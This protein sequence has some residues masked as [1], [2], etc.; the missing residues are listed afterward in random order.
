M[1]DNVLS[2]ITNPW[3]LLLLVALAGG[4]G[5]LVATGRWQHVVITVKTLM[6]PVRMLLES[7]G[8]ISKQVQPSTASPSNSNTE[9]VSN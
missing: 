2:W 5:Y 1:H 6:I 4:V 9:P 8:L 3:V 7:K